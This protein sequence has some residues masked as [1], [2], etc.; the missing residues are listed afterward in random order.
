MVFGMSLPYLIRSILEKNLAPALSLGSGY[1]FFTVMAFKGM[2]PTTIQRR[3]L[4]LLGFKYETR[5]PKGEELGQAYPFSSRLV[6]YF[7]I[8][9][10]SCL[11][12]HPI[13][14]PRDW[15]CSVGISSIT[16]SMSQSRGILGFFSGNTLENSRSAGIVANSFN[17]LEFKVCNIGQL[18][19]DGN[20]VT[21]WPEAC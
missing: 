18:S 7:F 10:N 6:N 19:M 20:M 4:V 14:L 21:L 8:S 2:Q 16:N 13:R 1:L 9:A 17:F 5:H 3:T 11:W 12:C 15:S